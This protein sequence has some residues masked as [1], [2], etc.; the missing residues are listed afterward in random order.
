M[1]A[2]PGG[3]GMWKSQPSSAAKTTTSAPVAMAL[4]RDSKS[5]QAPHMTSVPSTKTNN[6]S[7]VTFLWARSHSLSC[8]GLNMSEKGVEPLRLHAIWRQRFRADIL[9]LRDP[10]GRGFGA[11]DKHRHPIIVAEQHR[12]ELK[13]EIGA[14]GDRP[15]WAAGG[16][17]GRWCPVT[18]G[19]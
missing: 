5:L 3:F 10:R 19:G 2:Q 8:V 13:R 15:G 7:S 18:P 6:C 17:G 11:A 9:C 1:P 12:L 16:A 4:N 14:A